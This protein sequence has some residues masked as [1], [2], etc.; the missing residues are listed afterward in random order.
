MSP[1]PSRSLGSIV[2]SQMIVEVKHTKNWIESTP[3]ISLLVYIRD[4]SSVFV[5][6]RR[7]IIT[8]KN[9]IR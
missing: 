4:I 3:R 5:A 6:G 8:R 9:V 7:S 1:I 2:G